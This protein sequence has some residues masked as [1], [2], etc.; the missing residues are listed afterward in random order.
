L[1]SEGF[2]GD[3]LALREPFDARAR[4]IALAGHLIDALPADR[5]PHLFDLGAG[6]GSL[7][8][9]MAPLIGRAQ[10]WTLVDADPIL[11]E[12]ALATVTDWA[13][14]F[15][16]PVTHPGR[17]MVL[18]ISPQGVWRVQALVADLAA[19]PTALPLA[20]ADA[21]VS[22]AL[23]DLVSRR[24]ASAMAGALR[25]PFYAA[26]NVDGRG[27]FFPR[28][29]H[30]R[31]LDRGFRRDQIRDKGFGGRA[32]GAEAPALLSA[33]FRARGFRVLTAGSPW[34]IPAAT[35]AMA[36]ALSSG[37]AEA[38][39]AALP[40]S[41]APRIRAWAAARHAQAMRGKL[42]ARIGHRDVLA[43]PSG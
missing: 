2:D 16:W 17:G 38:A 39:L 19:G 4:S 15:G 10:S 31:L 26:L 29:V 8:R 41:A 12:R 27:G 5:P 28:H 3:W 25:V 23:C 18:V 42:S 43:L 22:S 7:F 36:D 30:D 24:W 21:V 32:V 6:T 40:A 35:P 11:L 13:E 14:G 1:S 37:H 9:W 20:K 34:F 33:A